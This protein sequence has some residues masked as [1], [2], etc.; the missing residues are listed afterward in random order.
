MKLEK[1]KS[2]YTKRFVYPGCFKTLFTQLKERTCFTYWILTSIILVVSIN[3][4][5]VL[6]LYSKLF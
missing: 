1:E 4:H 6:N 3:L 5:I 2:L